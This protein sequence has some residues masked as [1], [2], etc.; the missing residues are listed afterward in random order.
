MEEIRP[1]SVY[2][3]DEAQALLRM[4]EYAFRQEMRANKI[5]PK[6][7]GRK[8]LFLGEELLRYLKSGNQAH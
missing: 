6:I 5:H 8:L 4:K 2:T 7:T 3:F 1:N